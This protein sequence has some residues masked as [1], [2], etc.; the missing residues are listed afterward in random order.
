LEKNAFD[1]M[2]GRNEQLI[3]TLLFF[4]IL[5]NGNFQGVWNAWAADPW[6]VELI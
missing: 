2:P 3:D 6:F 1:G 4:F 5:E